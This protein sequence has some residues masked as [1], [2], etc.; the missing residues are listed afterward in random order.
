MVIQLQLQQVQG[1]SWILRAH[2]ASL[3]ATDME[4]KV[5]QLKWHFPGI[6]LA[7][8]Q[9]LGLEADQ[10][11]A[12]VAG[13]LTVCLQPSAK[14]KEMLSSSKREIKPKYLLM[15]NSHFHADLWRRIV[16]FEYLSPILL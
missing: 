7:N 6:R 2:P 1:T 3:A 11:K 16:L 4:K 13:E 10:R 12:P 8:L 15:V 9:L 5:E 14:D